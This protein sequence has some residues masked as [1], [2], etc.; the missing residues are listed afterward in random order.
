MLTTFDVEAPSN[1]ES[2]TSDYTRELHYE[3]STGRPG[4]AK[5]GTHPRA[6]QFGKL[7]WLQTGAE[8]GDQA[9]G[10]LARPQGAQPGERVQRRRQVLAAEQR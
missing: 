2:W 4:R 8:L 6:L 1:L 9:A 3:V 5:L 10:S 7:L